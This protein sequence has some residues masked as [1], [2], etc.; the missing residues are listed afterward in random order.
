MQAIIEASIS[1][2]AIAFLLSIFHFIFGERDKGRLRYVSGI[3]LTFCLIRFAFPVINL[4]AHTDFQYVEVEHPEINENESDEILIKAASAQICKNIKTL[5]VNRYHI[6]ESA[7]TVSVTVA[8]NENKEIILEA[9]TVHYY[10]NAAHEDSFD[11]QLIAKY[12][13]DTLAAP[14]TILIKNQE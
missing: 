13:S 1:I 7:F 5:I 10:Q 2:I 14:C 3:I 4:I 8:S 6:P 11:L 9:I 12:I